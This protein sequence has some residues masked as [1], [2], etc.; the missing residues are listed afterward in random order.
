MRKHR[1]SF[2]A[3]FRRRR[4]TH[5]FGVWHSFWLGLCLLTL[6]QFFVFGPAQA[7]PLFDNSTPISFF[8]NVASRLLSCELNV[9]LGQLQVYP[10]NQYTPAVH[11]LLQVTA[12]ILDAQNTN[13]YPSIFRPLFSEDASNHWFGVRITGISR[14]D[15]RG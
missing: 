7:N 13:F 14:L 12:N 8:T 5:R 1:R 10:T 4:Q 2:G 15:K 11:R 3:N 9:N 6:A